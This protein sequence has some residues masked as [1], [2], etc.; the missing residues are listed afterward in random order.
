MSNTRRLI[1]LPLIACW[2]LGLR[3]AAGQSIWIDE[4]FTITNSRY[5]WPDFFVQLIATE[6]RPPLHFTLFK[7][8]YELTGGHELAGRLLGVAMV[9]LSV[10]LLF[11]LTRRI[12]AGR[13]ALLAATLLALS[14]FWLLY[15]RMLRA[16]SQTMMLALLATV[17]LVWA[18]E[19]RRRWWVVYAVV[20]AALLYTDYSALAVLA[21]HGLVVLV[22]GWHR[23]RLWLGWGLATAAALAAFAPWLPN[24]LVHTDRSVRITD[25]A[26]GPVGF[27]LKMLFP[28]FAFAVGETVYPWDLPAL[29]AA[30]AAG[31]LV[32]WGWVTLWRQERRWFTL[33]VAG[34]FLPLLFTATLLTLIAKDITFANAASR[35]PGAAPFYTLALAIGLAAV[36]ARFLRVGATGLIAGGALLAT[37]NYFSGAHF[38][39]PI[40]TVPARP[41]AAEIAAL[42]RPGDLLVAEADTLIGYYYAQSDGAARYQPAD[43]SDH[44]AWVAAHRPQQVWI[45]TFG[46]DSTGSSLRIPALVAELEKA[47]DKVDSQGYG[48]VEESYRAFKERLTGRPAYADKLQVE[49][50]Q[51]RP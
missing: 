23:R 15:G 26:G 9:V 19:G 50:Y 39:N 29:L 43:G 13:P 28:W 7:L 30:P 24:I 40:Y 45:V 34:Y 18:L 47:Y 4:W 27:T 20:F 35:S 16:Y 22:A 48:H 25:L 44:A 37:A 38:L 3:L 31:L 21:G 46:R 2:W 5:P 33:A 6:R 14:P 17:A 12:A 11:A 36:P 10:A 49:L 32:L 51:K 42:A 41:V 8:W 1:L